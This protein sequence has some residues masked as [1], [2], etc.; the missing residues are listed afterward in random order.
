MKIAHQVRRRSS[1]P[2]HVVCPKKNIVSKQG[3]MQDLD[4]VKATMDEHTIPMMLEHCP[5]GESP[6]ISA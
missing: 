5:E 3:T 2:V 6:M 4:T 1:T